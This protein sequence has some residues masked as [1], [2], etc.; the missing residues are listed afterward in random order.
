MRILYI[1]PIGLKNAPHKGGFEAANRKNIDK[2]R[3]KGIEVEELAYPYITNSGIFGKLRYIQ[4]LKIPLILIFKKKNYQ[5]LHITP[6]YKHFIYFE[7]LLIKLCKIKG[8]EI[9]FDIRAGSFIHY[10]NQKS[11]IYKAVI[12]S[13]IKASSLITVEGKVYVDFIR[14]LHMNSRIHYFPNSANINQ[15]SS[16]RIYN[17]KYNLIYFGRISKTKGFDLLLDLIEKLGTDFTLYLAGQFEEDLSE[18]SINN[19]KIKYLGV[20]DQ[21]QLRET[22]TKMHFFIFP[23]KHKGEGQSNSLI[24]SMA[25]GVIPICSDN[26]FNKE[27]VNK[28]GQVLPFDAN[29]NDYYVSIKKLIN[30]NELNELSAGCIDHINMHHNLSSEINKLITFYNRILCH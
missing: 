26:G 27:V 19:L 28:Y 12:S 11:F 13:C 9:V 16:A 8:L 23:T 25:M 20:L 2:L 5:I 29:A 21:K 7:Y 3:E 17:A 14:N 22:L 18:K 1:G 15:I 6:L 4:L 24:E 10:Y 30:N